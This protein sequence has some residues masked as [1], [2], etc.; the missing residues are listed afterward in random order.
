MR[1]QE[2]QDYDKIKSHSCWIGD[3]QTGEPEYQQSFCTVLK[4]LGPTPGFPA[5]GSGKGT[6][7]TRK[8]NYAGQWD[9]IAET[10]NWGKQKL[11]C[12]R[13]QTKPCVHQDSGERN[14]ED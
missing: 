4:V 2:G 9:L 1:Q 10:Q 12:W 11:Q 5:W 6:M 8:S 13:A 7:I 3:P 14:I